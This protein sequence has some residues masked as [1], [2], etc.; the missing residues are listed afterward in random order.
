M[1]KCLG[2]KMLAATLMNE[3]TKSRVEPPYLNAC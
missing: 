2:S 1:W 3:G